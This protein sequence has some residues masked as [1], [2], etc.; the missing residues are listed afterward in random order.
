M[1]RVRLAQTDRLTEEEGEAESLREDGEGGG[2]EGGVG[3]LPAVKLQSP[4]CHLHYLTF[5]P[6][7]T[8]IIILLFLYVV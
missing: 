4:S 7:Q 1:L 2:E 6:L 3:G 8:S 5:N